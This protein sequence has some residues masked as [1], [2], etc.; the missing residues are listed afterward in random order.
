MAK[1]KDTSNTIVD[2]SNSAPTNDAVPVDELMAQIQALEQQHMANS[3]APKE[4][5]ASDRAAMLLDKIDREKGSV[6]TAKPSR[7]RESVEF[8]GRE[9]TERQ[10]LERRFWRSHNLGKLYVDPE[11]IPVDEVWFWAA[12]EITGIDNL[13]GINNLLGKEWTFVRPTEC[14]ELCRV[15]EY[16]SEIGITQ[17]NFITNDASILLKRKKWIHEIEGNI[18]MKR[19]NEAEQ[20]VIATTNQMSDDKIAQT[21]V[22]FNHGALSS[23]GYV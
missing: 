14:P 2:F 23:E 13:K 11:N 3:R 22:N 12:K 17:T 15:N 10:M 16:A 5:M 7:N 6:E 4:E 9:F 1:K 18:L 19:Q 20:K 8:Q 21:F